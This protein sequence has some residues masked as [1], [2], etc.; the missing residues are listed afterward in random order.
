MFVV[1]LLCLFE[2]MSYKKKK[3]FWKNLEEKMT[4]TTQHTPPT[5]QHKAHH[6]LECEEEEGEERV[7]A[8][9]IIWIFIFHVDCER[10]LYL[11]W[12]GSL[13]EQTA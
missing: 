8:G 3:H 5:N 2:M 12:G 11:V 1:F 9:G 6:P 4:M 7:K 10:P 13:L